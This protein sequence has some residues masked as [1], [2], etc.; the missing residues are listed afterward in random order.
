LTVE[1]DNN[2]SL[3]NLLMALFRDFRVH[4]DN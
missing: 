1:M 2:F 4:Q 3:Q